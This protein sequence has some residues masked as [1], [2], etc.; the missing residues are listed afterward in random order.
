MK[1]L[2]LIILIGCLEVIACPEIEHTHKHSHYE[3]H[4]NE[5][6]EI[7]KL[8]LDNASKFT[9]PGYRKCYVMYEKLKGKK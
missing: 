6:L 5:P 9:S 4:S 1:I 7:L 2:L 8:C 3:T